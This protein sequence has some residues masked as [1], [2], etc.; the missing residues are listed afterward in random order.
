[1]GALEMATARTFR[2]TREEA[3]LVVEEV[4]PGASRLR[5]P[6]DFEV[7]IL[8][9]AALL[10]QRARF[11]ELH[12]LVRFRVRSLVDLIVGLTG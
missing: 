7:N 4:L 10:R 12:A 3:R 8:G 6:I 1:M 11:G 9:D 5:L 2:T